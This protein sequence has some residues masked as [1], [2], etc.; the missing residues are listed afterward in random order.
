MTPFLQALLS[1][2]QSLFFSTEM[3]TVIILLLVFGVL[4]YFW[5]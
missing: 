4:L 5:L 3:A 1:F 2:Q